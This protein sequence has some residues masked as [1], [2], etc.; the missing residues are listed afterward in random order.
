MWFLNG[1]AASSNSSR[2]HAPVA[3][4]GCEKYQ[5]S[6]RCTGRQGASSPG[7]RRESLS[8]NCASSR[9]AIRPCA[10]GTC[11]A[12]ANAS[13]ASS[14]SAQAAA[15]AFP[16]TASSPNQPQT[17]RFEHCLGLGMHRELAVDALEEGVHGADGHS[18]HLRRLGVG[19]TPRARIQD[20]AFARSKHGFILSSASPEWLPAPDAQALQHL[21]RDH[22]RKR[23]AAVA[24]VADVEG[25]VVLQRAF[26]KVA[27]GARLERSEDVRL[28]AEDA[29]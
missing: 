23:G 14:A 17:I 13:V 28:V 15:A 5:L 16:V 2:Y 9:T 7:G 22:R 8:T 26:Q 3:P 10:G 19:E 1:P 20:L 6:G 25:D 27:S 4:A 11:A 12:A 21:A 24:D 18:Q 29:D